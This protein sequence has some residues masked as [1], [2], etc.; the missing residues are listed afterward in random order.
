MEPAP[1]SDEVMEHALKDSTLPG[2]TEVTGDPRM[3]DVTFWFVKYGP[4]YG[5][6]MPDPHS[7]APKYVWWISQGIGDDPDDDAQLVKKG[8]APDPE[9]ARVQAATWFNRTGKHLRVRR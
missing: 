1:V 2:W 9:T 5:G 3:P 4:F 6:V 7:R 8:N